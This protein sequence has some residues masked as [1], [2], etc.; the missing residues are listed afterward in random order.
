MP[1]YMTTISKRKKKLLLGTIE[2]AA[3]RP[4]DKPLKHHVQL[5][6]GNRCWAEL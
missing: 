1:F 3:F 6:A 4:N 5:L 2:Q